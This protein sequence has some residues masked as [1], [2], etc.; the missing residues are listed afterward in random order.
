MKPLTRDNLMTIIQRNIGLPLRAKNDDSQCSDN[1][2][3]TSALDVGG[4]IQYLAD[5]VLIVNQDGAIECVNAKAELLLNCVGQPLL[6][7]QWSEFLIG[8]CKQQYHT[9]VTMV[10]KQVLSLQSGPSEMALRCSD[11]AIKEVELSISVLPEPQT[12]IVLILRDL[13][14]YKAE[15]EQLRILA[16]TDVLTGLTNRRGFNE[17]LAKQWQIC[18]AKKRPLSVIIIDIDYF[19]QFNDSYGHIQGDACLKKVANAIVQAM[20]VDPKLAA[21]YGGE[22]FALILPNY[23]EMMAIKVARE[24]QQAIELLQ[25]TD[26]GLPCTVQVTVSQGVAVETNGQFRSSTALICAAD[27]ALYRAKADGR[28]CISTSC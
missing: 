8:R 20:P 22:E 21:R 27:T 1:L 13:T 18:T 24:V 4:F 26:L 3:P 23:N 14:R 2:N 19:K 12:R 10:T 11:G 6:G 15:C 9:L 28:D 17:Q 25:F 7:Q 5:A 16:S